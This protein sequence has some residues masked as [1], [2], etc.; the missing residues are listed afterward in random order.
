MAISS[1]GGIVAADFIINV[2]FP[3]FRHSLPFSVIPAKAG[4]Q[5]ARK[6]APSGL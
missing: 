2:S 1:G 6:G 4:I 3:P 5:R